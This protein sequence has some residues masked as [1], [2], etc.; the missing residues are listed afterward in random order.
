MKAGIC[1][2]PD[3]YE[4]SSYREYAQ[5]ANIIDTSF[6]FGYWDLVGFIEHHKQDIIAK[7]LD[8]EEKASIR[9]IDEQALELIK[10]FQSAR[11]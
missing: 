11:A 2:T 1:Q 9:V 3:K 8:I 4:Y 5:K 7:C 10:K 6:V